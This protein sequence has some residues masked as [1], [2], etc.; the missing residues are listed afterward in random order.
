MASDRASSPASKIPVVPPPYP[1][2]AF[3]RSSFTCLSTGKGELPR[4][5]NASLVRSPFPPS[6][7]PLIAPSIKRL[8]CTSPSSY[9][10]DTPLPLAAAGRRQA[11]WRRLPLCEGGWGKGRGM[12]RPVQTALPFSLPPK[13]ETCCSPP[14]TTTF[15]PPYLAPP[16]RGTK[17]NRGLKSPYSFPPSPSQAACLCE[18]CGV[19]REEGRALREE[20]GASQK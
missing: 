7:H 20:E 9:S 1:P 4:A 16:H 6:H 12:R 15:C 13:H 11:P 18:W 2:H 17:G 14:Q 8:T 3:L 10:T 5:L 19:G